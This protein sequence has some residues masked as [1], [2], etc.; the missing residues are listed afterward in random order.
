MK[1]GDVPLVVCK[2]RAGKFLTANC[3]SSAGNVHC[4]RRYLRRRSLEHQSTDE[5]EV[6]RTLCD[7][8]VCSFLIGPNFA[9]ILRY[10]FSATVHEF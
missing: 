5:Y 10:C 2:Q 1:F 9:A 4:G 7:G 6:E 8:C 3:T